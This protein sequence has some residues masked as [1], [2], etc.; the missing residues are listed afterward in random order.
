MSSRDFIRRLKTRTKEQIGEY[1]DSYAKANYEK[2]IRDDDESFLF[3]LKNEFGFTDE[4]IARLLQEKE[5][6][7][8]EIGRNIIEAEDIREGFSEGKRVYDEFRL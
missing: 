8:G 7:L 3:A 1:L 2:A 6:R 4:D 5:N